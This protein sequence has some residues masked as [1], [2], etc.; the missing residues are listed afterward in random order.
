LLLVCWVEP[1]VD[2]DAA[3]SQADD[4]PKL[5]RG[6][7]KDNDCSISMQA[8]VKTE[9]IASTMKV[10]DVTISPGILPRI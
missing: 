7:I 8:F 4:L 1:E 2:L 5:L 6:S 9:F 10:V 3:V